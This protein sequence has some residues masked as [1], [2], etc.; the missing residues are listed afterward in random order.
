MGWIRT[1][2]NKER[3]IYKRIGHDIKVIIDTPLSNATFGNDYL[4]RVFHGAILKADKT[5]KKETTAIAH[6]KK[7][8]RM[9]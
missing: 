8:M 1:V 3:I 2:N 9:H 4:V 7:Y 6:A 5:F